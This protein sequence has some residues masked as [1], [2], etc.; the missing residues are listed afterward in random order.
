MCENN[1]FVEACTH[2]PKPKLTVN[3]KRNLRKVIIWLLE[4]RGDTQ[5]MWQVEEA[6]E[7]EQ[8]GAAR[9]GGGAAV[10]HRERASPASARP[11]APPLQHVSPSPATS[12]A[13]GVSLVVVFW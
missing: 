5:Q 1:H 7:A 6:D 11:A 13:V 9:H 10:P 8:P 3:E 4:R 12:T 2:L